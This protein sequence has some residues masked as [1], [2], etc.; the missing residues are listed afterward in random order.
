MLRD[1]KLLVKNVSEHQSPLHHTRALLQCSLA[2]AW[3]GVDGWEWGDIIRHAAS[4]WR[5]QDSKIWHVT[6]FN[7]LFYLF[8]GCV[9]LATHVKDLL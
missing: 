5:H 8:Q 2:R 1:N 7:V 9:C 6:A 3:G 4:C